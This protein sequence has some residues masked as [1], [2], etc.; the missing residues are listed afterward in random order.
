M[1]VE[2]TE[3]L[4]LTQENQENLPISIKIFC[5]PLSGVRRDNDNTL[6]GDWIEAVVGSLTHALLNS[7]SSRDPSVMI[8]IRVRAMV[9]VRVRVSFRVRIRVRIRNRD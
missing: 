4:N 9:R 7:P 6:T 2:G 8:R 1:R 5:T 3:E